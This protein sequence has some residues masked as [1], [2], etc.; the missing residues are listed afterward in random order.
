M[1]LLTESFPPSSSLSSSSVR[2]LKKMLIT[3]IDDGVP[4]KRAGIVLAG[5]AYNEIAPPSA[6]LTCRKLVH[7]ICTCVV[8]WVLYTHLYLREKLLF[9]VS[10]SLQI[11]STTMFIS[12]HL[13]VQAECRFWNVFFF[14]IAILILW[15]NCF[16]NK[17]IKKP[18]CLIYNIAVC[19]LEN[20]L[21][22]HRS[23]CAAMR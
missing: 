15:C 20:Y 8:M 23:L 12:Y 7:W 4:P 16:F 2:H 6:Y 11:G 10:D 13:Q 17:D 19:A 22:H 14:H 1:A 9:S 18:M 21:L 5:C 3:S